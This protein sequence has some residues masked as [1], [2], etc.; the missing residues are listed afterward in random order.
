MPCDAVPDDVAS[1]GF[2]CRE[3]NIHRNHLPAGHPKIRHC[4]GSRLARQGEY[5]PAL[6]YD[7]GP[8]CMAR[9]PRCGFQCNDCHMFC[10]DD[11]SWVMYGWHNMKS[12]A[13]KGKGD[14][15]AGK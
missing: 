11:I 1:V 8:Y 6:S 5:D 14:G 2:P 12:L 15:R 10:Y 7:A 13:K 3:R 4:D 9:Y